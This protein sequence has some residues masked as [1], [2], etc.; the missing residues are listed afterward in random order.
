M[1]HQ[2]LLPVQIGQIYPVKIDQMKVPCS[3]SCKG[4][5]N[6]G[7]QA[8]KTCYGDSSTV[9]LFLY[10]CCVAFTKCLLYLSFGKS[11]ISPLLQNLQSR[12]HPRCGVKFPY[13]SFWE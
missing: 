7:T 4:K 13:N 5:S 10:S 11:H 12:V 3:D 1:T 8:A 9:Q 2:V 6:I